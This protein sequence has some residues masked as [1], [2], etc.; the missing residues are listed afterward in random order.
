MRQSKGKEAAA[1]GERSPSNTKH[2]DRLDALFPKAKFIQIVRDGRDCSVSVWFH[3]LRVTRSGQGDKAE[4]QL[5]R[6]LKGRRPTP[7]ETP[8][9]PLDRRWFGAIATARACQSGATA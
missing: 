3:N 9:S 6:C 8:P 5:P 2:L 1:I 4:A 7:P